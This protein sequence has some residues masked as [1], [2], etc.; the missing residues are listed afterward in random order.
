MQFT[1]QNSNIS[2]I[3]K[4][5]RRQRDIFKLKMSNYSVKQVKKHENTFIVMFD[6]PKDSPYEGG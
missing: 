6:G 2:E 1:F 5:K 3:Q 4:C